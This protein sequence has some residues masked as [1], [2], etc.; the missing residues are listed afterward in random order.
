[1][2]KT[3]LVDDHAIV[4]EGFKRL[5]HNTARYEVVAEAAD[6]PQAL[7]AVRTRPIDV[8]VIDLGLSTADGGF[9][10]LRALT[11]SAP[12]IRRVVVSMHDDPG[13]VLRA[14]DEGAHGYVT[15]ST[16]ISELVSIMDRVMRGEVALSSDVGQA[17]ERPR[18]FGLTPRELETL[19]GLL[20]EL[21][22]KAIAA[23]LGISVKTL[24]RH[25]TSLMVKLGARTLPALA[26]AARER[27]YL[28]MLH[29]EL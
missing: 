12:N 8:A 16:A 23:D 20:S 26:R 15:K 27:G 28:G 19:R 6:A 18:D 29:P 2:I 25:R 22:P 9:M 5:F 17:V 3:L 11:K 24:Y 21:P 4:R 10:L 14:L 1:M 7:D 13:V